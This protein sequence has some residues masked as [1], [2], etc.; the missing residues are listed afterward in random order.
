[1][2]DLTIETAVVR[3]YVA[4]LERL[5][6]HTNTEVRA[7]ANEVLDALADTSVHEIMTPL[8]TLPVEKLIPTERVLRFTVESMTLGASVRHFIQTNTNGH[9]G[10]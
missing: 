5:K 3:R 7:Y 2:A 10:A 6:N 9:T 4:A 1:M 8:V